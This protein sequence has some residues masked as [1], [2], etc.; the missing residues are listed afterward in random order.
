MKEKGVLQVIVCVCVTVVVCAP[1][2]VSAHMWD[3]MQ[4]AC[5]R[6]CIFGV[7]AHTCVCVSVCW[8]NGSYSQR[9]L[10]S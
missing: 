7:C 6:I 10:L 2:Y 9:I 3:S 5:E 4:Y 8:G 1:A